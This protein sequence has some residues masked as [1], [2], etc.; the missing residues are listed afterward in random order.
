MTHQLQETDWFSLTHLPVREG[1]Y[2][3][4][5]RGTDGSLFEGYAWFDGRWG[6]TQTTAYGARSSFLSYTHYSNQ[7]SRE[8][9]GIHEQP[10]S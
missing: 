10:K 3:T 9:K 4:R 1:A 2:K 7:Q 5:H 8:W 6:Y